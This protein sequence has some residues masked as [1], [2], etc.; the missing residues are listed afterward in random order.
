MDCSLPGSS[1]RG[2]FQ[3]KI[4]QWVPFPLPWDFPNPGIKPKSVAT[5]ALAVRFFTTEPA[6]KS[7]VYVCVY[8]YIERE[9]DRDREK[10]RQKEFPVMGKCAQFK[11]D[12]TEQ[13]KG[14]ES[15]DSLWVPLLLHTL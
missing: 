8:I 15:Q 10:Q 6:G 1:V 7:H 2:I 14:P 11:S 9:R 5:P 3:A 13:K 12:L 4:L